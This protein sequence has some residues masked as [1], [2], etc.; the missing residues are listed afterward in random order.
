MVLVFTRV[1][2]PWSVTG[3]GPVFLGGIPCG[4]LLVLTMV[5]LRSSVVVGLCEMSI[6]VGTISPIMARIAASMADI[7]VLLAWTWRDRYYL[8]PGVIV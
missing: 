1:T 5:L 8:D 3:L 6:N 4:G 7:G 2:L